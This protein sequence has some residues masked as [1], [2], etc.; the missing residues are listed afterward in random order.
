MSELDWD[1]LKEANISDAWRLVAKTLTIDCFSQLLV[2]PQIDEASQFDLMCCFT[3]AKA[4]VIDDELEYQLQ[5]HIMD[6]IKTVGN[7]QTRVENLEEICLHPVQ[8]DFEDSGHQIKLKHGINKAI[9]VELSDLDKKVVNWTIDAS[10]IVIDT[11]KERLSNIDQIYIITEVVYA[12]KV[13]IEVK[14]DKEIASK[15]LKTRIPVAFAYKTFSVGEDGI[16]SK[17][18]DGLANFRTMN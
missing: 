10:D 1:T 2:V 8:E 15:N 13:C 3:K 17:V 16:L 5:G 9:S 6:L 11:F 14:V 18:A 12:D 4:G 7:P